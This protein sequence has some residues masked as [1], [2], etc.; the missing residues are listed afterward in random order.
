MNVSTPRKTLTCT[1]ILRMTDPNNLR[2]LIHIMLTTKAKRK[3]QRITDI[4]TPLQ[5]RESATKSLRVFIKRL[6]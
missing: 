1:K 5:L 3:M 6:H 2:S 4:D